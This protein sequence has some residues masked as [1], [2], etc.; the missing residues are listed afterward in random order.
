MKMRRTIIAVVAL[1]VAGALPAV[2]PASPLLSGYGGPGQGNQAILG[3]SLLNGSRG[4]GSSGGPPSATTSA[5]PS[6]SAT[7]APG[8]A[9]SSSGAG[10]TPRP[11]GKQAHGTQAPVTPKQ[12]STATSNPAAIY[13]AL[14]RRA[15]HA[16]GT[17]GVTGEDLLYVL[18]GLAVLAFAGFLTSRVVSAGDADARPG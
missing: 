16:S 3:A 8:G 18:L 5:T 6:G 13:A 2:A 15:S 14:E 17:L 11:G 4:G 7:S 10:A 12:A 9:S 1:G